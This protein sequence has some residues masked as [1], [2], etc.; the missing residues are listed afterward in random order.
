M[1]YGETSHE[2]I[3]IQKKKKRGREPFRKKTGE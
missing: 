1:G 2:M 3:S